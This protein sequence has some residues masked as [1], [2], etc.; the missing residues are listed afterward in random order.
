MRPWP[1]SPGPGEQARAGPV[2]PVPTRTGEAATAAAKCARASAAP[3][4]SFGRNPPWSPASHRGLSASEVSLSQKREFA[5]GSFSNPFASQFESLLQ[6]E[7]WLNPSHQIET[8][9]SCLFGASHRSIPHRRTC[10]FIAK[11]LRV[12]LGYVNLASAAA[13]RLP[14]PVPAIGQGPNYAEAAAA[15]FAEPESESTVTLRR[16]SESPSYGLK[17]TRLQVGIRVVTSQSVTGTVSNWHN[18]VHDHDGGDTTP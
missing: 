6:W 15:G 5:C 14:S 2:R 17:S 3:P 1:V 11:D 4:P 12:S 10:L 18:H 8:K 7:G 13:R 16:P 9:E